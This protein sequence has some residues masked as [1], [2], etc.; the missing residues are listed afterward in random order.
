MLYSK[1]IIHH[2]L[3]PKFFGKIKNAEAIG[4]AG[5][6]RCGDLMKLYLKID[7]K[8]QRIKDVKF[9]TT[10]CAAA[11][12]SSDMICQIIKGKTLKE[13]LN[14]RFEDIVKKLGK[15]PPIKVHCS[16]LATEALKKAADNYL[17][18]KK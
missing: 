6:I 3:N 17:A 4:Q 11:I 7:K 9:E 14:V 5:N 13:A 1:K 18:K 15:M 8:S 16:V 10:G 2:F 12:A